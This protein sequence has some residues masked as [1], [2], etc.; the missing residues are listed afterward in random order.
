MLYTHAMSYV[1]ALCISALA[2]A[3]IN[4]LGHEANCM[5][6]NVIYGQKTNKTK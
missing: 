4:K 3:L 1:T 6:Y 2:M 5:M